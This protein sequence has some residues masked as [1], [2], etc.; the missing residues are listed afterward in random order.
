MTVRLLDVRHSHVPGRPLLDGVDAAFEPGFTGLVGKN[1]A[2]KSTLLRLIAG[3]LEPDSGRVERRGLSVCRL[4]QRLPEAATP[5]MVAFASDPGGA[6][7]RALLGVV[8]SDL[9]RFGQLS[10]GVRRRFALGAALFAEPDVLLLDEPTNHLDAE[11]RAALLAALRGYRGIGVVVSH[12]RALLEALCPRTAWLESGRLDLHDAPYGVARER[13]LAARDAALREREQ[14]QREH[15]RLRRA[16]A[17]R[18]QVRAE[19]ERGRSGRGA[20][21]PDSRSMG[22]RNRAAW[23]E[24]RAGREVAVL[25]ERVAAAAGHVAEH[26]VERER[27]GSIAWRGARLPQSRLVAFAGDL[28]LPIPGP[29]ALLARDLSLVVERDTRVR[30]RGPNGAGKSTLLAALAAAWRG[31][32]EQLLHLP[33]EIGP[34][35]ARAIQAELRAASPRERGE[36]LA[37]AAALGLDPEAVMASACPSPG[38][39]RQLAL[40]RALARDV[41]LLLLDE[42]TNDLDLP[43][44]ER[45]Q[46][47]LAAWDGAL[48]L[49]TH[50]DAFAHACASIDWM[51]FGREES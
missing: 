32:G 11:A 33:Q 2:G 30:L 21:L 49:V 35:A 13:R 22:Q 12:D 23:A 50:D 34:V 38:E 10:P 9:E 18:R 29:R 5:G 20:A 44:I 47:A 39:A 26:R 36:A 48:V 1:G 37:I 41:A 43:A 40:A 28:R 6:R 19:A 42:P 3:E 31:P 16:L 8:A 24:G 51:P 4:D 25:A 27:G 45:L 17:G 7:L 46:A 15:R 14:L